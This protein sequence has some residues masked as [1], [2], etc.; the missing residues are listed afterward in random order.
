VSDETPNQPGTVAPVQ[1]SFCA[2]HHHRLPDRFPVQ[3]RGELARR[4]PQVVARRDGE[5]LLCACEHDGPHWWPDG[6][7]G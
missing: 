6:D 7:E 2:L 1:R 4:V 5:V 3:P